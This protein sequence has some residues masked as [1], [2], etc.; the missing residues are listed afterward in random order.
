MEERAKEDTPAQNNKDTYLPEELLLAIFHLIVDAD[1]LPLQDKGA[2][3]KQRRHL[4][5]ASMVCKRWHA[6][7]CDASLWKTLHV[8]KRVPLKQVTSLLEVKIW[9]EMHNITPNC[10][11]NINS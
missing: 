11:V 2:W 8:T 3:R 4:P 6:V 10:N 9:V 5:A 1:A 7:A